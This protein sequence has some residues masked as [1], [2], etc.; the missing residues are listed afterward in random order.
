VAAWRRC[1]A[2]K[3]HAA[4]G[5]VMDLAWS[6]DGTALASASIDAEVLLFGWGPR[7]RGEHAARFKS[8]KHFVQGLAWDPAQQ[9]L[10]SQSADRT[11]RWARGG[12][13]WWGSAAPPWLA[14]RGPCQGRS[15]HLPTCA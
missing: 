11:V 1:A 5:D 13:A 4:T 6:P 9:H 7:R 14:F 2:L 12:S 8:H 15:H 10:A 3:G